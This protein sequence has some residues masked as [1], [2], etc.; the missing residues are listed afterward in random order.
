MIYSIKVKEI[1]SQSSFD[2]EANSLKNLLL[3]GANFRE[4]INQIEVFTTLEN[5]IYKYFN[6]KT[7]TYSNDNNEFGL[8]K[9]TI[10][11]T[12]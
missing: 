8:V 5:E 3:I 4:F 7:I 12:Y 10:T 2:I 6:T 1:Q 9:N 11:I